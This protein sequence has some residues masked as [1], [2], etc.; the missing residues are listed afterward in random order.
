MKKLLILIL[1]F[2]L[3]GLGMA[4]GKCSHI[5]NM[6]WMTL[7]LFYKN[8][9]PSDHQSIS[10]T[11]SSPKSNISSYYEFTKLY[12]NNGIEKPIRFYDGYLFKP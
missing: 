7:N 1:F 12:I 5:E 10:E 2:P 8:F 9:E 4:D 3:I 6:F 11:Y